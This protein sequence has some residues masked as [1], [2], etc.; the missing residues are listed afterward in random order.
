MDEK[1]RPATK[2]KY[3]PPFWAAVCILF[4]IVIVGGSSTVLTLVRLT[5]R[6]E[7]SCKQCHPVIFQ[8][9]KESKG[10]PAQE[11]GCFACHAERHSVVPSEYFAD[12]DLTAKRC[13]ECHE[14]VLDFG[15]NIKKKVIKFNHRLHIHEGLDCVSCH[16][17]AGHEYMT[18]G[19]NRPSI[20]QCRDCH[21]REFEGP[22]KN[23]KCLNCHDVLL[24][25]GK[26]Q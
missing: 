14:N 16:R 12:D 18:E 8:L 17:S 4:F 11:S 6:H 1:S 25:P 2:T 26:D 21:L 10:H 13:L 24:A 22:P 9:W 5:G 23:Q 3:K 7:R 19:T 15:Y 20:P